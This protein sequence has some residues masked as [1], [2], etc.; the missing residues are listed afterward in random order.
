MHFDDMR[1]LIK[2]EI[3]NCSEYVTIHVSYVDDNQLSMEDVRV[4]E[5]ALF[6][7]VF[8]SEEAFQNVTGSKPLPSRQLHDTIEW[9]QRNMRKTNAISER[10]L[11]LTAC[12]QRSD[13]DKCS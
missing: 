1:E 7:I 5:N 10:I 2:A 9:V 4:V 8:G 3:D 12:L 13:S 6:F 11:R